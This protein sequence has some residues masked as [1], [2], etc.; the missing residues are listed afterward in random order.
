MIAFIGC[1]VEN[2]SSASCV[3]MVYKALN[4]MT[5]SYL[6]DL[7]ITED[8]NERRR[9]LRSASTSTM[10][11][12]QPRRAPS[13]KIGDHEFAVAAPAA[14]NNLPDSIRMAVNI[15]LF[16]RQLKTHLFQISFLLL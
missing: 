4:E 1:G 12:I 7:C 14:L 10:T 11:L 2:G 9:T 3:C 5:P 15:D 8:I 13:T 6:S 16:K